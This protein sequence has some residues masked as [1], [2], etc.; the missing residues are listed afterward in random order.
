MLR[1]GAASLS[2]VELLAILLRTGTKNMSAVNLAEHLLAE[3]KD[4]P[5]LLSATVEELSSVKGV[6]PVKAVQIKAALELSKRLALSP[7]AKRATIQSPDD[8]AALVMENMRYLDREHFCILLL[9]TKN[10]VLAVETIS[11]GTLNSSL[12]HPRELFKVAVKRSAAALILLHNHPSGDPTPSREDINIT[13]RIIESGKILGI[14]VLDHLV[15]GDN[16]Y[17]S[18]K[19][20]GLI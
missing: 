17:T 16:K 6:G 2:N 14:S 12:V 1:N 10:Q 13:K 9:N 7:A 4:L 20:E 11:V 19:A 15:I 5:G 8:A 18:L 3:F